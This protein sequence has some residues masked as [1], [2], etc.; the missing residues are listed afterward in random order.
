MRRLGLAAV[1]IAVYGVRG[2]QPAA[3]PPIAPGN[4][5]LAQTIDLGNAVSAIAYSQRLRILAAA[6]EQGAVAYWPADV[7]EGVRC[8]AHTA[9]VLAGHSGAMLALAFVGDAIAS[10]SSD[11]AVLARSLPDGNLRWTLNGV[12]AVRSAAASND[13]AILATAAEDSVIQLWESATGKTGRKLVGHTDWV[14]AMAFTNDDKLL[15]SGGYDGNVKVWEVAT[16]KKILDAVSHPPP[17]PNTPPADRNSVHALAFSPDGKQLATGGS[18]EQIYLINLADGKYVRTMSGHGSSVTSLTFHPGG[19]LL[20]S[21]SKDRTIRLW[22]P[23]NGQPIKVLE[24]HTA[25]V[26]SVTLMAHGTR[27]ASA[28]A[29]GTVRLWDLR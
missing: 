22:D 1:L 6:T 2:Q 19:K 28:S 12:G 3:L 24:G 23:T 5:R 15:A 7:V 14:L 10:A 27:L 9:N 26:E 18:D 13:G 17:A 29:D 11:G 16:G 21:G 8:G 4:A 20:V 25:W